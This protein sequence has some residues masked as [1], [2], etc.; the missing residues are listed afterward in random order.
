MLGIRKLPQYELTNA[1]R[2]PSTAPPFVRQPELLSQAE[3]GTTSEVT[4]NTEDQDRHRKKRLYHRGAS[5]PQLTLSD[6]Q[7]CEPQVVPAV[8]EFTL[9]T[10]WN[11]PGF[12]A[13]SRS[14]SFF[15]Y[16]HPLSFFHARCSRTALAESIERFKRRMCQRTSW[17]RKAI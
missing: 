6:V 10:L 8:E 14:L 2:P 15:S 1:N 5:Q 16:S 12:S 9:T 4:E 13:V 7:I 17:I 11:A 3:S